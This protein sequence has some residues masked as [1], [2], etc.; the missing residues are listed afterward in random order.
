[1]SGVEKNNFP[2]STLLFFWREISKPFR[3][4]RNLFRVISFCKTSRSLSGLKKITKTW[5]RIFFS[6]LF[7]NKRFQTNF[8]R[9]KHSKAVFLNLFAT[10]HPW[11]AISMFGGTPRWQTRSK[12]WWITIIGGIPGTISR[13]LSWEPLSLWFFEIL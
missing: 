2:T 3:N 5:P 10:R 9:L 13:H 7:R 12:D 11:S 6:N 8:L 4:Q 1:M